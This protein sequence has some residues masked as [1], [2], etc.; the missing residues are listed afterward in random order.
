MI[1]RSA[2]IRD[3][4]QLV[5][6]R[7][8][9]LAEDLGPLEPA[10]A[11]SISERLFP[12]FDEHMGKGLLAY[13]AE[14]DGRLASTALVILVDKP[15]SP[16]FPTGRT[17]ILLNVYTLPEFRRQG[18]AQAL[19]CMALDGARQ[20]GASYIELK[21]TEAGLDLYRKVGFTPEQSHYTNMKY[22][23]L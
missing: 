18:H 6:L 12:Y 16:S 3:I 10:A 19:V 9:Y 13:V 21:A 14:Q 11:A 8:S 4:P 1:Y 2:A 23:L 15:A 17:A 22:S 5:S 20:N 7:L